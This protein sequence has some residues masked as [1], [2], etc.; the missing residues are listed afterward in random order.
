MTGTPNLERIQSVNWSTSRFVKSSIRQIVNWS[1]RQIVEVVKVVEVVEIVQ[2]ARS[3]LK[4]APTGE[5]LSSVL[6]RLSSD[7]CRQ[8]LSLSMGCPLPSV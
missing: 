4:A 5:S 6:C 2:S 3:R 1:N 7:L 8:A